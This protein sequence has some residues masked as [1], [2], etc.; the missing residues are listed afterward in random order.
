MLNY[1][2]EITKYSG[3]I[4]THGT[5]NGWS[6][7]T[8]SGC[9]ANSQYIQGSHGHPG[10]GPQGA[11]ASTALEHLNEGTVE[12]SSTLAS[13]YNAGAAYVIGTMSASLWDRLSITSDSASVFINGSWQSVL[14]GFNLRSYDNAPVNFSIKAS[15]SQLV[16]IINNTEY[17]ALFEPLEGMTNNISLSVSC[18]G[19]NRGY[20][21]LT[22]TTLYAP[23]IIKIYT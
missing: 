6:F 12:F 21:F 11:S 7:Y 14:S 19:I 13:T 18:Q 9:S 10:V 20:N 1:P 17:K 3:G 5:F 16:L 22:K 8:G 2:F 15:S 4:I 23:S